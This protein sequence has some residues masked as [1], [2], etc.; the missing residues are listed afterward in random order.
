MHKDYGTF[1]TSLYRRECE[2]KNNA[3]DERAA[4]APAHSAPPGQP[5][6]PRQARSAQY[7]SQGRG[8]LNSVLRSRF[9]G[10]AKAPA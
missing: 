1:F 3:D 4:G 6:C 7:V 5:S 2:K 8:S 9:E 10:L